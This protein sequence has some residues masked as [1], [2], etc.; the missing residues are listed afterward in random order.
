MIQR[1]NLVIDGTD[2]GDEFGLVVLD[3]Y[4]LPEPEPK[5]YTIDVPGSDGVIDLTEYGGDVAYGQRTQ[6]LT[7]CKSGLNAR[8]AQVLQTSLARLIQGRKKAFMLGVDS[9]WVY[10]GRFVLGTSEHTAGTSVWQWPLKI[11]AEPYKTR[12]DSPLT[13]LVNAAG[14]I[15]ITLPVGR[16]RVCPT[17]EVQRRTLV[18]HSGKTWVLEAGASKI[19]DLW[20]TYGDNVITINTYP[21]YSIAKWVDIGNTALW[22]SISQKLWSEVAAGSTPPQASDLWS[23]HTGIMWKSIGIKRWIELTHGAETGDEYA[24]YI[25]YDYQD[26]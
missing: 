11:T 22:S 4:E 3:G 21:E 26:I 9:G 2:I 14:G 7:L 6:T 16:K 5:T 10:T 1:N 25:Q 15:E 12:I 18:T 24:A 8:T 20:L 17:I 13:W 19:R 23:D